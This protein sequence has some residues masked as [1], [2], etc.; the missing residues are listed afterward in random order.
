L[1]IVKLAQKCDDDLIFLTNH[2]SQE[3]KFLI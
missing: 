3:I 1:G 2:Q